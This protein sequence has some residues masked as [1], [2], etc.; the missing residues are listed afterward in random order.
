MFHAPKRNRKRGPYKDG[1]EKSGFVT[2]TINK[3][4]RECGNCRWEHH[5]VCLNPL[6]DKDEQVGKMFGLKRT[7]DGHWPVKD[8]D[9]C[10]NFQNR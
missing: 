5:D 10:D 9:C 4:P 8:S 1:T 3:P 7:A 6:T 2:A